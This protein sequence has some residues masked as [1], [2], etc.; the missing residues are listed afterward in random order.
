MDN[1]QIFTL[2]PLV[3]KAI[4]AIG[5]DSKNVQQNYNYRGIEAVMNACHEALT[6]HGVTVVP[7]VIDQ[8]REERDTKNGGKLIYSILTV[9]YACIAPDGSFIE[10]V[11]VGEGMDSG[12]KAS[13]KALSTAY[14]YF[15]GQVFSIPFDTLDSET[16]SHE[17]MTGNKNK[18]TPSKSTK[19]TDDEFI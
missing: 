6:Q 18:P 8:K 7:T 3:S 12:D 19:D 11:V 14:K 1:K 15:M 9:K 2:L 13:N 5:K 17:V 16:E 10:G 4:G